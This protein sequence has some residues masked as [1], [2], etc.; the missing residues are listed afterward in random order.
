MGLALESF[1]VGQLFDKA[2]DLAGRLASKAPVSMAFAKELLN[3]SLGRDLKT[4]LLTEAEAI[5]A[6]MTT[7][8]WHEGLR[9]FAEKRHPEF[10]GK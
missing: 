6:C 2:M 3:K 8:D 7:E 9:S 10:N 1:P 4:V 5:L